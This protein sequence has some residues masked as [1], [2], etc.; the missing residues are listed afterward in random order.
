MCCKYLIYCLLCGF[1]VKYVNCTVIWAKIEVKEVIN[2]EI[3]AVFE[4][5]DKYFFV[6]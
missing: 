1:Y 2:G 5:R 4:W 6:V 3:F